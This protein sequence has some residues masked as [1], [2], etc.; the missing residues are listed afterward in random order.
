MQ[1]K[2]GTTGIP[3]N[4]VLLGVDASFLNSESQAII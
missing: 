4:A 3:D 2:E 1:A